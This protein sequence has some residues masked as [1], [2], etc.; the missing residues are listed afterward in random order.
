MADQRREQHPAEFAGMLHP[1][2]E[3]DVT[4]GRKAVDLKRGRG[5]R[6]WIVVGAFPL[7][8]VLVPASRG[9]PRDHL[10]AKALSTAGYVAYGVVISWCG[11]RVAEGLEPHKR[12][13][14]S[15]QSCLNN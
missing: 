11:G 15:Q 2:T 9:G 14:P 1:V 8:V 4:A 13:S 6:S 5:A 7:W 3:G 12:Q 10:Q